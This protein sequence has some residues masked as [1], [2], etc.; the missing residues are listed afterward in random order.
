MLEKKEEYRTI[1]ALYMRGVK[2]ILLQFKLYQERTSLKDIFIKNTI[3]RALVSID[4]IITLYSMHNET[5]GWIILRCL[6][7]RLFHLRHLENTNSYEE[8]NKWSFIKK[9]E[10]MNDINSDTSM[11]SKLEKSFFQEFHKSKKQYKLYKRENINWKRGE[12]KKLSK[13]MDM[14]FLYKYGYDHASL[15]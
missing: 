4:A 5:D 10:Y 3:A 6:L 1:F 7:E 2:I 8:F 15:Y 14:P 13:D 12:A 9:Y 11:K